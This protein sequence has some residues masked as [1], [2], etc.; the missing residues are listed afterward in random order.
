[1]APAEEQRRSAASGLE[2]ISDM[3]FSDRVRSAFRR[4]ETDAV[5]RMSEAEITR[6]PAAGDAAG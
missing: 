1:M 3:G 5:V 4:G 6:A 2:I